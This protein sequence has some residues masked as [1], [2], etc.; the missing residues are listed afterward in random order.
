VGALLNGGQLGSGGALNT[1]YIFFIVG[2]G[3]CLDVEEENALKE[4]D[5]RG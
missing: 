2:L 5:G 1:N 4:L 3:F